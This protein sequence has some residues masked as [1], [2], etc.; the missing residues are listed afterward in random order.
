MPFPRYNTRQRLSRSRSRTRKA[1]IEQRHKVFA[2][3]AA[4]NDALDGCAWGMYASTYLGGGAGPIGDRLSDIVGLT[5]FASRIG[6][7]SRSTE[8][9]RVERIQLHGKIEHTASSMTRLRFTVACLD[10]ISCVPN[11]SN[12]K[13]STVVSQARRLKYNCGSNDLD[14]YFISKASLTKQMTLKFTNEI[15]AIHCSPLACVTAFPMG[16]KRLRSKVFR[17]DPP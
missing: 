11:G 1:E 9:S 14:G 12:T 17:F 13:A 10:S 4:V 7:N 2:L 8:Y 5:P 15:S 3:L 6:F 16:R